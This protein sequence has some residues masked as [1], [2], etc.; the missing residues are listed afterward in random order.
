MLSGTRAN[1]YPLTSALAGAV[2][3]SSKRWSVLAIMTENV[4]LW[5]R[6]IDT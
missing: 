4:C 6:T 2:D 1:D 5:C 3:R